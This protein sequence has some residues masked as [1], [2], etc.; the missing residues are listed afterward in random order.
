MNRRHFLSSSFA[1]GTAAMVPGMA[2]PPQWQ[3]TVHYVLNFFKMHAGS[4]ASRMDKF[5]K[6]TL[7]PLAKKHGL[8][9][10]GLFRLAIG[11][12]T[13]QFVVLAE[14]GGLAEMDS[15]SQAM[16]QDRQWAL[17]LAELEAGDEA[18]YD[19]A[20]R[21]LLRATNYSPP[22][23]EAVGKSRTPRLFEFR[24]YHSPTMKQLKALHER[25]SGPEIKIFH[26]S[27]IYPILFA[28]TVF[29][30]D[31]PNLTYLTPFDSL[32][33]REK[34]WAKFRDDP[35]WPEVRA[36]SIRKAGQIV[37]YSNRYILN[38]APY[39]PLL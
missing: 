39:S 15:R 19:K 9:P 20:E 21:R 1:A 14:V 31:Y 8:G 3:G 37:A 36:E 7:L 29:G 4:Q 34:A 26:R 23:S 6:E 27:G 30:P 18:P 2:A 35:E 28:D 25:F 24:V 32:E 13:P 12:E 11:P 17:G 38:A 22:L 16:A 10:I 5:S 33:A